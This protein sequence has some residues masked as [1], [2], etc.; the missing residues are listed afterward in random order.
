MVFGVDLFGVVLFGFVLCGISDVVMIVGILGVGM[1]V[2]GD[3][4]VWMNGLGIVVGF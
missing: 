1:I 4:G 3:G 2:M